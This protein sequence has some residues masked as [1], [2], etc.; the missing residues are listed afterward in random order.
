MFI[1]ETDST[2]NLLRDKYLEEDDLFTIRADYQTAGRGQLG[3]GWESE[4]GKNL[5]FSTLL[6]DWHI[7]VSRQFFINQTVTLSLYRAVFQT[8]T[9]DRQPLLTVKWPN[10]I[11]YGDRKLAGILI[12]NIWHG[13]EVGRSI[14]GIGLNVNQTLFRSSAPNPISLCQITGAEYDCETLLRRFLDSLRQYRQLLHDS[15]KD[16]ETVFQSVAD[17]Y[18]CVLYRRDG[19]F[20]W[21]NREVSSEP[22]MPQMTRNND[23]FMARIDTILP[24]GELVLLTADNKRRTFHFKQVR[25]VL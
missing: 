20:L 4:R 14:A 10:D 7:P 11:Y 1:A 2:N 25:Y 22:S 9:T 19:M 24:S 12:E 13:M 18:L 16:M 15:R 6:C 17:E 21:E 3:N 23:Q 8:L 5:L